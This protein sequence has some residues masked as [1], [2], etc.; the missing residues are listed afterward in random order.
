MSTRMPLPTARSPVPMAAVVL[1]LPGPVFTMIRPLR[2]SAISAK[3]F[4]MSRVVRMSLQ[5]CK[6]A[7]ELFE[8]HDAGEFMRERHLAE[9]EREVGGVAGGGGESVCRADGE[10]ELLRAAVLLV[11]EELRK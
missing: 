9:R 4:S 6:R 5:D 7:I 3:S 2:V 10:D 8:Q 11:A 1:P